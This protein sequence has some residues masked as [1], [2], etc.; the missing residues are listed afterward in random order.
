MVHYIINTKKKIVNKIFKKK[1][2]DA[3]KRFL[4]GEDFNNSSFWLRFAFA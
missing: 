4:F 3:G 2:Y 1:R